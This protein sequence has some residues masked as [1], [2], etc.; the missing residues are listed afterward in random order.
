MR[1]FILAIAAALAA[2]PAALACAGELVP[3]GIPER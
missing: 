2:T 1:Y 3:A